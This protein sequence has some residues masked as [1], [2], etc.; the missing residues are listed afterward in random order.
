MLPR[1]AIL[2]DLTARRQA[3]D[4]G[5]LPAYDEVTE[6]HRSKRLSIRYPHRRIRRKPVPPFAP[7]ARH[8]SGTR[9]DGRA[10]IDRQH[11]PTRNWMYSD[12]L[13]SDAV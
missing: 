12:G 5:P 9:F 10:L 3:C 13:E 8:G 7:V 4:L 1:S 6:L 2:A 11:L